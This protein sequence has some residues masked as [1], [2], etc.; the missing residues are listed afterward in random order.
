LY[1]LAS[2][3]TGL[4]G[5]VGDITTQTFELV[6]N[7]ELDR[8][9]GLS[10]GTVYSLTGVPGAVAPGTSYPVFKALSTDTVSLVSANVGT[11]GTDVVLPF[12]VSVA[13]IPN[14]V[15]QA[16]ANGKIDSG[17]IDAASVLNG[18]V[19]GL[20][21]LQ[22]ETPA[23]ARDVLQ[24]DPVDRVLSYTGE[25]LTGTADAYG[26]QSFSYDVNDRLTG[27]AGT[28]KYPSKTFI[29]TGDQLTSILVS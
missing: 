7:G 17:W 13:P 28:G 18:G 27:I 29:Y 20:Q 25:L 2:N 12:T 11:S 26:T 9:L 1:A 15:P 16:G 21:V 23:D 5:I 3:Q 24:L 14:G 6:T 22:S 4:D 8:L 10:A 19:T